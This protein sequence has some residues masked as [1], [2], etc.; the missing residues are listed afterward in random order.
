VSHC[1]RA[2]AR[3]RLGRAGDL[4]SDR[5][6]LERGFPWEQRV[7]L[8][9]VAGLPIEAGQVLAEDHRRA[10]RG[11]ISPAATLSSVDLPQPVGPT[12]ATNSPSATSSVQAL[13]R[14]I[15]AA[16]GETERHGNIGQ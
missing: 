4:Q 3:V 5:D 2:P 6:V 7:G 10:F 15:G 14:R 8:E 13:H 11:A 9:Q 12:I 16:V 1:S